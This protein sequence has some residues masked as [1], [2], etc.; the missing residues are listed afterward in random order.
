MFWD[1]E[2][3]RPTPN[4]ILKKM[5]YERDKGICQICKQKVDPFNFEI[6]H[7]KAHSRGGKL[8]LRN[9]ILLCPTCNKSMSVLSVKE[10]KKKLGLSD[11]SEEAKKLLRKMT[12][13]EL[14][15]IAQKH[16]IKVKG[17]VSEGFFSETKLPPSKRQ[18]INA[19]AKE[20][21]LE[22]IEHEIE[23]IPKEKPEKKPKKKKKKS[24]G[25]FFNL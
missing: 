25:W 20:L 22:K 13:N 1:D 5:V 12:L 23:N 19:L 15:Y 2:K 11:P 14:K 7:N 9:A 21:S 6:G 3:K 17:R 10:V 16:R 4:K 24:G 18:Y 8:T